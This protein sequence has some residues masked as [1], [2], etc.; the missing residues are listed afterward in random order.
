MKFENKNDIDLYIQTYNKSGLVDLKVDVTYIN[1]RGEE[2]DLNKTLSLTILSG[3]PM[4]FSINGVGTVYN[5]DTK[6]FEQKFLIS[7]SDKYNNIVNIASKINI[8]AM[9]GFVK[10]GRGE[11]LLFGNIVQ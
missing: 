3:E 6:W 7:A 4:A 1:N 11:R 5:P 9:A 2:Y 8:S 10:N